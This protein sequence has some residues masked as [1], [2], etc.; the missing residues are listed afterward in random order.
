[1]SPISLLFYNIDI[2][3]IKQTFHT[4]KDF[5][6]WSAGTFSKNSVFVWKV[7]GINICNKLVNL[8][9]NQKSFYYLAIY[10]LSIEVSVICFTK[11]VGESWYAIIKRRQNYTFLKDINSIQY[12]CFSSGM[13]RLQQNTTVT[14]QLT[15]NAK[16]SWHSFRNTLREK[17]KYHG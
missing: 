4:F 12:T 16:R 5:F 13:I 14:Q 7:S 9:A 3:F 2:W 8:M 15:L 17:A 1:M 10:V 11:T 6:L